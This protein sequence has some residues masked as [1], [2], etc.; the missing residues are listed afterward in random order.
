M[1]ACSV[2]FGTH[3]RT[4]YCIRR[5]SLVAIARKVGILMYNVN[6]EPVQQRT[7]RDS[8][9]AVLSSARSPTTITAEAPFSVPGRWWR[10]MT[11]RTGFVVD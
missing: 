4:V 11:A 2:T 9:G 1:D 10:P 3:L 6:P 5:T 7:R 8:S